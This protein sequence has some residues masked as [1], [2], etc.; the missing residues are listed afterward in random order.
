MK[1]ICIQNKCSDGKLHPHLTIYKIYDLNITEDNVYIINDK[2]LFMDE[3][4]Y[5]HF[6]I[7]LEEH[8]K[9]QLKLL[10]V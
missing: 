2:Q 4:S 1:V 5:K 6:F 8:R 10:G 3:N 9:N 7:T